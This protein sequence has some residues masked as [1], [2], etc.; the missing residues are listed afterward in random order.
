MTSVRL[1]RAS[2]IRKLL[3]ILALL[4]V[5][6]LTWPRLATFF[7]TG[8]GSLGSDDFLQYWSAGR[9]VWQGGNPYDAR[10]M[11]A[12]EQAA[13]L[14]AAQPKETWNP[15][16]TLLLALPLA[17]LPLGLAVPSF[18]LLQLALILGSGALL[19]RY[20]SPGDGRL[21][22]GPLLAAAFYPG[23]VALQV[24]QISP[25]L[26]AGIVGFLYFERSRHDLLAG[27]A[28][29]LLMIK[30]HYTYLFWP[31]ALLWALRARR[32][33]LIFGWLGALI[34]ASIPPVVLAPHVYADYF[35]AA[36]TPP[37]DWATA[38]L[39]AWL[40]FFFGL[41]HRWLQFLPAL[42]GGL[43]FLVWLSRRGL[44]WRWRDVAASLLLASAVTAAYGWSYDQVVLLPAV[45]DLVSRLRSYSR[46]SQ[47]LLLGALVLFQLVSA[48]QNWLAMNEIYDAWQPLALAGLY[49]WAVHR[50]R[51][52]SSSL[53]EVSHGGASA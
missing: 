33:R 29:A 14:S 25:W 31:A 45:V 4:A 35:A 42:V 15:P 53:R 16:W 39:G 12:V 2:A 26:L 8:Y 5:A 23:L 3:L 48:A 28:L 41:Q 46:L 18:L 49:W 19:W 51:L 1:L 30:P 47:I 34:V 44:N 6:L 7:A 43:G 22:I 24:G 27:A 11:L 20:Y 9:L 10:S 21:W 38:T 17:L 36:T 37:L 32:P 13:G 50:Q 40:R 52:D